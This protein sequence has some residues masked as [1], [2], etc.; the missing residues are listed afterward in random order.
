MGNPHNELVVKIRL[1]LGRE[2]DLTLW[3]LV[4]GVVK[5][6]HT[7]RQYRAGLTTGAADL[8][9][10]LTMPCGCG[11]WFCLEAKTGKGRQT[12]SQKQFER[13]IQHRGGYYGVA[14]TVEDAR[15]ALAEARAQ[16]G[17]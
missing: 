1:A 9:G 4:Q 15:L 7:G 5:N 17:R 16:S 6:A 2:P 3:P 8:V 12:D 13:L 14:R 10:I 11:R